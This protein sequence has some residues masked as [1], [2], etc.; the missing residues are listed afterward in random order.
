MGI[1]T[2][3]CMSDDLDGR[4]R[5][6]RILLSTMFNLLATVNQ[7]RNIYIEHITLQLCCPMQ[8]LWLLQN[9]CEIDTRPL[10]MYSSGY[11]TLKWFTSHRRSML[12]IS[13]WFCGS[14][15]R[16]KCTILASINLI[17]FGV[18]YGISNAAQVT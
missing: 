13:I 16:F 11:E 4:W 14:K 7:L 10:L 2:H 1:Q 17:C 6:Q 3:C 8:R 12:N 5:W 9:H 18:L 15:A